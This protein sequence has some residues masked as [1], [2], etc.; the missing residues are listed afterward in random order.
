LGKRYTDINQTALA[1]KLRADERQLK[2]VPINTKLLH[3]I[4]VNATRANGGVEAG[5][6]AFFIMAPNKNK[7][8]A[9]STGN[10]ELAII[11]HKNVS[12]PAENQ[13]R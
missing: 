9:S 10:L 11:V 13:T 8:L 3:L 5:L 2:C 7:L 4:K 1:S 6:H 12:G